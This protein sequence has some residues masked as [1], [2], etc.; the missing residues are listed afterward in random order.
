[1]QFWSLICGWKMTGLNRDRDLNLFG[2]LTSLFF[3]RLGSILVNFSHKTAQN[4]HFQRS[5]APAPLFD[6]GPPTILQWAL[7]QS[8]LHRH[9]SVQLSLSSIED[10][11][12]PYWNKYRG[13]AVM[14]SFF[15]PRSLEAEVSKLRLFAAWTTGAALHSAVLS[16]P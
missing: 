13:P 9:S 3:Y 14:Q 12:T 7:G 6:L 11:F 10:P 16:P 8:L 2:P 1:M 4:R 15:I 5:T